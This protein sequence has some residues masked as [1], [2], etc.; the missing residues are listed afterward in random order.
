LKFVDYNDQG[1]I[2]PSGYVVD[3]VN[4][5]AVGTAGYQRIGNRVYAHQVDIDVMYIN[6][7]SSFDLIRTMLVWDFQPDPTGVVLYS[8]VIMDIDS[9]GF[10]Y[11][12][13]YSNPSYK[14][15]DRF[16]I[17][18]DRKDYL[19]PVGVDGYIRRFQASVDL[20]GLVQSFRGAT[21]ADTDI[22][23]GVM[24]LF[25]IGMS[26]NTDLVYLNNVRYT[27]SDY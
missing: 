6:V 8:D 12:G 7:Q 4:G 20:Q 22:S 19:N 17:L 21:D 1:A 15:L 13:P 26:N 24:H 5:I 3:Y 16:Q 18:F 11:T 9:T 10:T 2:N 25:T 27:Y 23:T 14:S